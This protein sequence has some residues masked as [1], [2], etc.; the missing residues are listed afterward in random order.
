MAHGACK[1]QRIL[2]HVGRCSFHLFDIRPTHRRFWSWVTLLHPSEARSLQLAHQMISGADG[3]GCPPLLYSNIYIDRAK[4]TS[5]SGWA[6]SFSRHYARF[7]IFKRKI[8]KVSEGSVPLL[9]KSHCFL[10]TLSTETLP[11]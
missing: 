10:Y 7:L 4:N 3:T 1:R 6:L 5:A 11:P 8:Q 9:L 2:H